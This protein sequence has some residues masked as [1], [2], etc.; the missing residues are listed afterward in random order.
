MEKTLFKRFIKFN[1]S[2]SF[3]TFFFLTTYCRVFAQ[4]GPPGGVPPV[5]C[6]NT[7]LGCI[8]TTPSRLADWFFQAALGIASGVALL[9]VLVGGIKYITS[10]GDFKAID[11]AK[12]T[13]TSALVGFLVIFLSVLILAIIGGSTVLDISGWDQFFKP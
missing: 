10:Q 5:G 7:A 4:P 11:E 6:V 12:K 13:I 3:L 1:F 8:P 9:L 2:I